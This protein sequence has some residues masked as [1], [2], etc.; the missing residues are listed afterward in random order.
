MAGQMTANGLTPAALSA[1]ISFDAAR[2]PNTL[3]AAKSIVPG[4]ANRIASG[5]T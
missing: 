5:S 4:T 2:R 3:A 1:V